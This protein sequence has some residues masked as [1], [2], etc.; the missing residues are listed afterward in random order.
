MQQGAISLL[1]LQTLMADAQ[2]SSRG[3]TPS[4]VPM[5]RAL[6]DDHTP[7]V[8]SPLNPDAAARP[9]PKPA[10]REQREKKDSLKKRESVGNT[11]GSTPEKL[12]KKPRFLDSE[13]GSASPVRYN[14]PL[15]RDPFHYTVRDPVFAS[16]E[17]DPI[18]SPA[19]V[20]LKK[21]IDQ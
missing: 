12:T 2:L 10:A 6:D 5:K 17:P 1:N 13:I 18:Y 19:G 21:P 3:A 14:H 8:S 20:E 4:L 15:P 7:S 11:R 9:R 16:H